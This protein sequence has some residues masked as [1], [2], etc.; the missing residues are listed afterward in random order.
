LDAAT[1]VLLQSSSGAYGG[2]GGPY[3]GDGGGGGGGDGVWLES[4][5]PQ[6]KQS[7]PKGHRDVSEPSPPSSH[8]PSLTLYP[9]PEQRLVQR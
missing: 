5:T 2:G 1:H 3:G 6:S 8:V 7:E 9:F 4:R